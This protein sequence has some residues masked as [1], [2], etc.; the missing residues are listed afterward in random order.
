M[1]NVRLATVRIKSVANYSHS[2]YLEEP[3]MKG[4]QAAE[5]EKRCWRGRI[6]RDQDGIAFI[7]PMAFKMALA[8][9]AQFLSQKVPGKGQATFTKHF[10]AG[11]MVHEPLSLGLHYEN[12]P[13]ETFLVAADGK[14]NGSTRVQRTFPVFYDWGGDVNFIVTDQTID[15]ETFRDTLDTAGMMIGVGRFRPINGG[16]YGRFKAE[17]ITWSPYVSIFKTLGSTSLGIAAHRYAA[18]RKVFIK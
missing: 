11:V 2:K 14:K 5:Y 8:E 16:F 10:R 18:Q 4:E 3:K 1:N 15:E 12:V 9:A 6:H 17:S 7:P 13:G